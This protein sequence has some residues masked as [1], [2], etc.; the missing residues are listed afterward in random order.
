MRTRRV[1]GSALA[2][3]LGALAGCA[4]PPGPSPQTRGDARHPTIVSLNPC[5]D[6]VLA[7]VAAPGQLLAISHYSHDPASSSMDMAQARR[8]R[9]VSGAVEDVL[10]LE[11][12]VVVAGT[13]LAP[14]TVQAFT[15]L[16]I[17][18]ETIG[19]ATSVADSRA[20]VT[21]L[22]ALA[23]EPDRGEALN[24]KID[25]ALT[26]AAPMDAARP[27]ALVWQGGGIVPGAQ[28]LVSDLLVRTGFRSFSAARGMGQ[29]DYLPLETVLAD[30]PD[31]ILPAG[32]PRSGENR[33]LHHPALAA[34]TGTRRAGFPSSLLWCG[35]P[36]I[37]RAAQR[38]A[39]VRAA[40]HGNGNP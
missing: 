33:M 25:A 7:E 19:I 28:T 11:P 8:F 26:A 20:Q 2:V 31:V 29:A 16:G 1:L 32:D 23:G 24:R 17:R 34:L 30:P 38:L 39:Q 14:A 6:A 4:S 21:K 36:T 13:F 18:V 9:S 27:S 22:A 12:D 15:D 37:A 3:A 10:A 35:G 40:L 5:S